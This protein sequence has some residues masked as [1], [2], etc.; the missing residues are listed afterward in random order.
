MACQTLQYAIF[1]FDNFPSVSVKELIHFFGLWMEVHPKKMTGNCIIANLP[2]RVV[3]RF[4][5]IQ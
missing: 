3:V 1:V 5:L 2:C 4:S